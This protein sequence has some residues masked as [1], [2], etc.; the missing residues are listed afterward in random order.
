MSSTS[1]LYRFE[2]TIELTIM[3]KTVYL[4]VILKEIQVKII[5]IILFYIFTTVIK[6]IFILLQVVY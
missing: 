1:F 2:D 4:I 3:I 5:L 6:Y